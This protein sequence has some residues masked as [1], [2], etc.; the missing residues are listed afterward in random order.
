MSNSPCDEPVSLLRRRS[1]RRAA[2]RQQGGS[3]S[4]SGSSG[5]SMGNGA[6]A[7]YPARFGDK[8]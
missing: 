6:V 4:S 8:N 7:R 1:R 3:G 5:S 2:E